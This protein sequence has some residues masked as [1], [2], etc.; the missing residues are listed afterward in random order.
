MNELSRALMSCP[1]CRPGFC[2]VCG[3]PYPTGHHVVRRSRL[4]HEGPILDLCGHG[5]A[6]C[7][8][9]AESLKLHFRFEGEWLYLRTKRPTRYAD[10]LDTRGWRRCCDG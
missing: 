2:I 4:G 10:A 6:G 5:T 8:G 7:H 1:S 9:E 3:N